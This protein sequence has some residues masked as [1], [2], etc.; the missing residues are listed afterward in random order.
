MAR[1]E[2]G[3]PF[4][5]MHRLTQRVERPQEGERSGFLAL[6]V[7]GDSGAE[8]RVAGHRDPLNVEIGAEASFVARR[9][10][11]DSGALAQPGRRAASRPRFNTKA[12]QVT[13]RRT[14]YEVLSI[15]P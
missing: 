11:V 7:A 9:L 14:V 5:A 3:G 6:L 13:G 4:D 10:E 2:V 15:F 8:C 1:R 12:P